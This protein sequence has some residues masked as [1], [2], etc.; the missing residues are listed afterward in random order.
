MTT[1]NTFRGWLDGSSA[2][3]EYDGAISSAVSTA[4]ESATTPLSRQITEL[5]TQLQ[6]AIAERDG[7]LTSLTG[8]QDA[9]ALANLRIADLE[10][11]LA[12][13]VSTRPVDV[14]NYA[15]LDLTKQRMGLY[16]VN[17]IPRGVPLTLNT[18][19]HPVFVGSND[20]LRP[21]LVALTRFT[22]FPE[23]KSGTYVDFR[24]N[25]MNHNPVSTI[26]DGRP[27]LLLSDVGASGW[28]NVFD[29]DIHCN[30]SSSRKITESNGGILGTRFT[31]GRNYIYNVGDGLYPTKGDVNLWA[32]QVE[33][34]IYN[35]PE[36]GRE[37]DTP[38]NHGHPDCIQI[39]DGSRYDIGWNYC[40]AQNEITYGQAMVPDNGREGSCLGYTGPGGISN[41]NSGLSL[42]MKPGMNNIKFH[43]DIWV[44]GR[45]CANV[46]T[47]DKS[48]LMDLN[49]VSM[50]NE[51][52]GGRPNKNGYLLV[53][54]NNAEGKISGLSTAKMLDGSPLVL[55]RWNNG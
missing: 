1:P 32:N 34:L 53:P 33:R 5:T 18:A 37:G 31:A 10:R 28:V 11:S 12:A 15:S 52:F 42:Q 51:R 3:A 30:L 6:S 24:W 35:S 27:C 26:S 48:I 17:G 22:G 36:K 19:E 7:Y 44:N 9:L 43:D 13:A 46:Y 29:N 49:S 20:P 54:I 41:A 21:L 8:T 16:G 25:D 40:D 4:V 50:L 47:K 38:F 2:A 45:S 14:N 23:V 55:S 39:V